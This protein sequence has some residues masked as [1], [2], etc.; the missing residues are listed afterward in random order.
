[1]FMELFLLYYFIMIL[2]LH[3][4]ASHLSLF[5]I[6]ISLVKGFMKIFG[7]IPISIKFPF[8]YFLDSLLNLL[9]NPIDI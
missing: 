3:L 5:N 1:M 8:S 4:N 2:D 9:L 7:I 6:E